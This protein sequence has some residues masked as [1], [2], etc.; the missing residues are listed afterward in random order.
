MK[1]HALEA[2]VGDRGTDKSA[3]FDHGVCPIDCLY[4]VSDFGASYR[5]E[6]DSLTVF[7]RVFFQGA[8]FSDDR[9]CC[10]W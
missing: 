10:L 1:D 7:E 8:R 5:T 9:L 3:P 4:R 6:R 2:G